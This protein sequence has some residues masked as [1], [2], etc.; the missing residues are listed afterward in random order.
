MSLLL[1]CLRIEDFYELEFLMC[2]PKSK[3]V[4]EGITSSFALEAPTSN[5]GC[6]EGMVHPEKCPQPPSRNQSPHPLNV[7]HLP[8]SIFYLVF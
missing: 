2:S 1:F 6:P 4:Q 8:N 3:L 7:Q 5:D